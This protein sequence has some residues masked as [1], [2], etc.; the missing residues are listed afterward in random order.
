M[1]IRPPS[2]LSGVIEFFC[3]KVNQGRFGRPGPATGSSPE[4][5]EKLSEKP[6][7]PSFSYRYHPGARL[8]GAV[9]FFESVFSP[10]AEGTWR[11][12]ENKWTVE[13]SA[14]MLRGT[15]L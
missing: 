8:Q 1:D 4:V 14:T 9:I 13:F 12:A 15:I 11:Y 6:L 5:S 3:P 2:V 7:F 10:C